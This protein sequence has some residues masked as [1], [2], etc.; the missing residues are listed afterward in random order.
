MARTL[1]PVVR[2]EQPAAGKKAV[3][4]AGPGPVIKLAVRLN[5]GVNEA[6]R[7]LIRYRG[8][9]SGMVLEALGGVELESTALVSGEDSMVRDTTI[10]L[11]REVHGR[12]KRIA[13]ERGTSMN[14]L[15]N[16]GLAYWLAGKGLVA[17][18]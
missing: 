12:L 14:I 6:L 5:E 8:D 7:S 17:L 11:P 15:V 9:L 16:T 1:K 10:S 2:L 3:K 13:K 18:R 4:K